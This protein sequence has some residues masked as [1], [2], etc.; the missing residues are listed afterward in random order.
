MKIKYLND[1][2]SYVQAGTLDSGHG[3]LIPT[4]LVNGDSCFETHYKSEAKCKVFH[5]IFSFVCI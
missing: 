1:P 3:S 4:G 5:M 2:K